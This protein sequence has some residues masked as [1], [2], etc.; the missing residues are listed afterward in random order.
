MARYRVGDRYL[1][2]A[3]HNEESD[4]NWILGLFLVGAILTGLLVNRSLVN[5]EW[6]TAF[7]FLVTVVPAVVVGAVL[8]ALHL[9]IR[10]LLFIGF[11]LLVLGVVIS[12][13]VS[14]V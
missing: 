14:M 7:R 13:I 9:W 8:A 12:V 6:H 5:P 10:R 11:G 1:S 2:E 4:G 3:E